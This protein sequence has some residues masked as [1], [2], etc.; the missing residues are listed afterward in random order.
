MRD[1]EFDFVAGSAH[2]ALAAFPNWQGA[3]L[4]AALSQDVIGVKST[5]CFSI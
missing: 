3:K 5:S 2:S 1:G 4:L